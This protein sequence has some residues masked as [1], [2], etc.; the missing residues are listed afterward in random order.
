MLDMWSPLFPRLGRA[1]RRKYLSKGVEDIRGNPCFVKVLRCRC[2]GR[3]AAG[4]RSGMV[5]CLDVLGASV[6]CPRTL[7][8]YQLPH[9]MH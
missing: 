5:G 6:P 1:V 2:C 4:R 9:Q 7:G 3:S 8:R